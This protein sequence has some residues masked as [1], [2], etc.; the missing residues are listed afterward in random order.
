M[1]RRR[2]RRCKQPLDDLKETTG[3]FKSKKEALDLTVWRN[4][5][6]R[7]YGNVVEQTT[8]NTKCRRTDLRNTKCQC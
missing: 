2:R 5:F 8:R 6:R 7:G 3:Y 4:R 1:K